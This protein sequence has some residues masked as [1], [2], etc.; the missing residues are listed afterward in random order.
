MRGGVRSFASAASGGAC[1]TDSTAPTPV[2][3]PAAA[4]L[5]LL[6][7]PPA[8][9]NPVG[10]LARCTRIACTA[11]APLP[12]AAVIL[13][14]VTVGTPA[15]LRGGS[16]TDTTDE[17]RG[18]DSFLDDAATR[19]VVAAFSFFGTGDA[20]GSGGEGAARACNSASGRSRT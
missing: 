11:C 18:T 12:A 13:R 3:A 10:F 14:P 4:S 6:R 7:L 9:C 8:A 17:G 2:V 1:A 5:A 20:G 16:L 15:G 19:R